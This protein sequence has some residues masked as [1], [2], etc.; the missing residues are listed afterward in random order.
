[1]KAFFDKLK[2]DDKNN[3]KNR[4]NNPFANFGGP[5]TFGGQGQS[6][7]GSQ[8]G[9]VFSVTLEYPGTLGMKIEKR[10]NSAGSAIVA[11]VVPGGQAE[12]AGLLR[13]DILCWHGKEE[14][15]SYD[16]FIQMASSDVRP[17]TFDIRRIKTNAQSSASDQIDISTAEAYQRKQAVIAAAEARD[18]ASKQRNKPIPKKSKAT[19]S[20][21]KINELTDMPM[22]EEAKKAV[23]AAKMG[24]TEFAK[25][26]GYNPYETNKATAGQ[27]RN[28]TV[29][30]KHGNIHSKNKDAVP[31]EVTPP[32][33]VI[34][35]D[36]PPVSPSFEEAYMVVVTSNPSDRVVTSFSI[37]RK[38]IVNAT[39]K[40][41]TLDDDTSAKFRRVRLANDKIKAAI[42]EVH[43]ALD[44]MMSVGFHLA[45]EGGESYLVYP[46]GEATP[47]WMETGLTQMEQYEINSTA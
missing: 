29:A 36:L 15:I 44:L 4:N 23:Q 3:N 19:T 6:L 37:M 28:A 27:A 21:Q 9:K 38:L 40:G 7:G 25:Q 17:L 46:A 35:P 45:E 16:E 13:G 11:M 26:L 24:E 39:T 2:G 1:M 5:R 18:K 47:L 10:P 8:P 31:A 22:S 41:Q 42:S 33:E 30:A 34:Q 20:V 14:E 12:I 43:G 32:K